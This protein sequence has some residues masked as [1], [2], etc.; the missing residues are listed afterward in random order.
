MVKGWK[1]PHQATT[2]QYRYHTT[3]IKQI[4]TEKMPNVNARKK[5]GQ[6]RGGNASQDANRQASKVADQMIL[7]SANTDSPQR[8]TRRKVKRS[9]ES[10]P[11]PTSLKRMEGERQDEKRGNLCDTYIQHTII[12]TN[13]NKYHHSAKPFHAQP[14]SQPVSPFKSL[15]FF[16]VKSRTMVRQAGES[17]ISL[18]EGEERKSDLACE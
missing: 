13:K 15:F 3:N 14:A 18:F 16:S 2:A 6:R 5:K 9:V 12:P 10:L 17:G 4:T 11:P 7:N 1:V 8:I